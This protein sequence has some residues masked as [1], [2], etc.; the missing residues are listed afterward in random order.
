MVKSSKHSSMATLNCSLSLS[1]GNAKQDSDADL[2][3]V[4]LE[5][6]FNAFGAHCAMVDSRSGQCHI[7]FSNLVQFIVFSFSHVF[8]G[9]MNRSYAMQKSRSDMFDIC[10]LVA[11]STFITGLHTSSNDKIGQITVLTVLHSQQI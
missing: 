9:H 7:S 4:S 3:C 10:S 8:V 11:D 1:T 6:F 2:Q 5:N